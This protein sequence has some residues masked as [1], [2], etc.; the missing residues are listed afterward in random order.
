M[1]EVIKVCTGEFEVFDN[2]VKT[3]YSIFNSSMGM[4]GRGNNLYGIRTRIGDSYKHTSVG[5][6]AKAK[7]TVALWIGRDKA[8]LG[9]K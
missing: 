5:S 3:K 7:K 8:V 4:S 9:I 6:L 2:G 1:I